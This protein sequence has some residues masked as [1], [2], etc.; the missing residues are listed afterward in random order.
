[1]IYYEITATNSF[2][3]DSAIVSIAVNPL[4][5]PVTSIQLWKRFWTRQIHTSCL[6]T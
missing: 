4:P 2:G 6:T 3:T 1:R 5:V